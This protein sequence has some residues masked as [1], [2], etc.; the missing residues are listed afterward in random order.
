M[1]SEQVCQKIVLH[2]EKFS[3]VA[4]MA[5]FTWHD[6]TI[7]TIL[8]APHDVSSNKIV[9]FLHSTKQGTEANWEGTSSRAE[10]DMNREILDD[11]K[12]KGF[13][14]NQIMDHVTSGANIASTFFPEVRITYYGNHT[15]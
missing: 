3:W 15:A 6:S 7:Q 9:W 10:G 2:G 4:Y 1:T 8:L 12:A 11:V 14:I 13:I 5:G